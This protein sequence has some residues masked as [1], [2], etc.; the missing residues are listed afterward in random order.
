MTLDT[1]AI[2]FPGM[3]PMRVAEVGKF[4]MV[5]PFARP[6]R[7]AADAVAGYS[8]VERLIA[9]EDDYSEAAQLAFLV[10]CVALARWAGETQGIEPLVCTGPSFGAKTVAAY[11]GA[12]PFEEA[13][14]LTA[15]FARREAEYFRER[16]SDVV[17]QSIARTAPDK[18]AELLAGFDE[19]GEWYD[20]SCYLDD[21]FFMVSLRESALDGFLAGVKGI[22]GLPLY[23]M[24][25]P[26]HSSAFDDLRRTLAAEV[27][28]EFTFADPRL[29]IVS[30]QD[31]R[32]VTTADGVRTLLLDGVVEAVRWPQV[33]R[34]LRE[35]SVDRLCVSGP[36]SLFGRTDC[37]VRAFEV[38]PI[39]VRRAMRPIKRPAPID[40]EEWGSHVGQ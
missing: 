38:L 9:D 5:N 33:V 2:V 7:K 8:L 37:S 19:R 1:T 20:M 25:P 12:L 21:D 15:L 3:G 14:R 26:M 16:H 32:I 27:A 11:S 13:V 18:L 30:D 17:T 40:Q 39:D 6:L 28:A 35:L 4:L 10:T 23:T 24:R 29:P 34:V 31:G 22:G 36:D